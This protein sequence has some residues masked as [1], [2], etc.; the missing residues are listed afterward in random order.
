MATIYT[1]KQRLKPPDA[2]RVISRRMIAGRSRFQPVRICREVLWD[3][4]L[5]WATAKGGKAIG[6][7]CFRLD[8]VHL[9]YVGQTVGQKLSQLF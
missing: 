5:L 1:A 7:I 2:V 8:K 4:V 6:R 3:P 9:K